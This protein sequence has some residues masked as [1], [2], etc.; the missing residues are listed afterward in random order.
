MEEIEIELSDK[1]FLVLA[2]LAHE[3]DITFNQLVNNILREAMEKEND[4]L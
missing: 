2:K 4:N 1:D 3:K